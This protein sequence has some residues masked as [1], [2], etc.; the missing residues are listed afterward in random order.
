MTA[1][2]TREAARRLGVKVE[3]L[4]AYVSRGLVERQVS[5][6]GRTSMFDSQVIESLARRG[7]PRQSSRSTSLNMLIETKLTSLSPS[8]VRYRGV[9]S[10]E[11]ALSH[12]FED[13]A[14]LIWSGTLPDCSSPWE[15]TRLRVPGSHKLPLGDV[16]RLA[17]AQAAATLPHATALDAESVATAGRRLI[18]S[19]TDA[20]P[21]AGAQGVPRLVLPAAAGEGAKPRRDTIAGRLWIRL[22]PRRPQPGMLAVLNGALVLLA[23]HELA[24]STLAVRVAATTRADPAAAITTGLGVLS[25]PLH[26]G[27]S[28]VARAMLE[29]AGEVGATRAVSDILRK[30]ERIPGFGHRVYVEADPRAVV[31]LDLLHRASGHTRA[32]AIVD[33]V[34]AAVT[35]SIDQHANVD[36]A[37]AAMAMIGQ[38]V[39][40]GGEVVMSIARMAGWLG[41]A[42]EE[43]NESPLRFRPRA[44][45][46]G[47]Q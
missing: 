11:L 19:I 29:R 18:A 30:G 25:G 13:V 41:H 7:R 24:A 9:P 22:S 27:A 2:T 26:G 44:S 36:Y 46:I 42:I 20:L 28:R 38:M 14:E 47:P 31:L 33:D 37:L 4:Y 8:G 1:L 21:T 5:D 15:A 17:A 40:D 43:Y 23:D 16:V 12:T 10:S 35:R 39:T 6:D 32:M 3:T 34:H 45:Y